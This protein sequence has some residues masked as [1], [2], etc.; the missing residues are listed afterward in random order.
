M[1]DGRCWRCRLRAAVVPMARA[2]FW[3][4]AVAWALGAGFAA[5]AGEYAVA[6]A[7]GGATAITVGSFVR[8][9]RPGYFHERE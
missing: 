9:F 6:V 5:Q 3:L 2:V 7:C 1:A 4:M 8:S